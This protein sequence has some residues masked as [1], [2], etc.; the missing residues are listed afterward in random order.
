MKR[1]RD[2]YDSICSLDNLR[3]ADE[4]A[5]K[6]KTHSHGVRLHDRNK[7]SN[8]QNLRNVLLNGT[9]RTSEYDVFTIYEPKER[10]IHR[11]PYYP[12]R[13]VH[14][15][16]MNILEPIWCSVFTS[17]TYS[18]IKGRGIH[19]TVRNVR[20]A[21]RQDISGTKYCLKLDIRKFYPSIK[22]DILKVIIRRKLKDVRL[23]VLLDEI[24]DSA[25]GLPIGNYLSQYFA[26]LYLSYFDHWI[27][28]S[29]GVKNY[30][31]YADDIVILGNDKSN[32]HHLFN[33]IASYMSTLELDVKSNWQVFPVDSR[34][35]D[36]VGYVFFHSHTMMR[37]SIKQTLCRRVSR[38]N[39]KESSFTEM[40]FMRS[41]SPWWG[42]AKHCD[43]KNLINKLSKLS[44]YE[45]KFKH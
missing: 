36:F 11:L 15:A 21:L 38:M 6:G 19:A 14:H 5:R 30:F 28:E 2:L 32:L 39:K 1:V 20:K 4:K 3:L 41:I 31:R 10:Q 9:Y 18:C 24:I 13:I 12:D 37:K 16:I 17:D 26:N 7:E 42:W 23:L 44:K 45:I 43:S 35:I 34:G 40:E 8:I 22:H 25:D 29:K 33:D 27:K